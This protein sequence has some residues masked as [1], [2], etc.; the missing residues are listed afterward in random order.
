MDRVLILDSDE[1][2]L[3]YLDDGLQ[4]YRGQFEVITTLTR[5]AA[6]SILRDE[7]V[8]VFVADSSTFPSTGST[9]LSSLKAS[10][11]QVPC[12]IMTGN[13][14]APTGQEKPRE[15]LLH[16]MS[17]PFGFNDLART[18]LEAL[19]S[20][21]EGLVFDKR[22]TATETG[23]TAEQGTV[24]YPKA[25]HGEQK[26]NKVLVVD[27]SKI[28]RKVIA[29]ALNGKGY[30]IIE[31]TNATEALIKL[32]QESPDLILLDVVLP[33][34]DGYQLLSAIKGSET[35]KH[36]PVIMLTAKDSLRDVIKG[37]MMGSQSYLIKPFDSEDLVSR[38]KKCLQKPM[39]MEP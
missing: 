29:I 14:T 24:A 9:L 20:L 34:I 11:L 28:S 6:F 21:D 38:V 33:D 18:I 7:P 22:P 30:E 35:S 17:K 26:K 13:D 8:S 16:S 39:R 10:H 15:V 1:A 36:I 32:T 31:A 37:K 27:D 2:F 19:R 23:K 5:D 12:I 3:N 25:A 4:R